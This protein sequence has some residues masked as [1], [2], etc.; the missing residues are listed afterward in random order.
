MQLRE[1]RWAIRLKVH[2]EGGKPRLALDRDAGGHQLDAVLVARDIAIA[3]QVVMTG[4]ELDIEADFLLLLPRL[5]R[6][7]LIREANQVRWTAR[8]ISCSSGGHCSVQ[9]YLLDAG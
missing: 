9:G 2:L 1:V 6:Y 7:S 8:F 5:G 4:R 3:H